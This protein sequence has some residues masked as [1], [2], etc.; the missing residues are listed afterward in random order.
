MK[1]KNINKISS[2]EIIPKTPGNKKP[3]VNV[4]TYMKKSKRN[5]N[6]ENNV[7]IISDVVIPEVVIANIK[8]DIIPQGWV[9]PKDQRAPEFA[10]TPDIV[11][12][13]KA[14]NLIKAREARKENLNK[15]NNS[16]EE[17]ILHLIKEIEHEELL[18]I[19]NKTE[20]LKNKLMKLI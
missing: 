19:Q 4:N 10:I 7:D 5:G 13:I 15:K 8:P 12:N 9:D 2:P 18:N 1:T 3:N 20:K 6:K 14:L 11:T 17:K 16:R